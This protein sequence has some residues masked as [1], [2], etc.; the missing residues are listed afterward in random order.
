MH[1]GAWTAR[2]FRQVG[3]LHCPV[4]QVET[5]DRK[6]AQ[7]I[8]LRIALESVLLIDD[9]GV[10]GEKRNRLATRGAWLLGETLSQRKAYFRTLRNA[11]D[12]AS[13]VLHAGTFKVRTAHS[14]P[15]LSARHRTSAGWRYC[16]SREWV[17][18]PI[19]P[20]SFLGRAF[21]LRP[22]TLPWI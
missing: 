18:Y 1:G 14:W 8:E 3:S 5:H 12:Y 17:L 15:R 21:R 13:I 11:Y 2:Q 16:E 4:A 19:G 9:K 7:L 22:K 20:V 6:G 10:V